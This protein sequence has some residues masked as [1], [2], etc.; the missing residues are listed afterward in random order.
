MRS[1]C[2]SNDLEKDNGRFLMMPWVKLSLHLAIVIP[3]SQFKPDNNNVIELYKY[4]K[5]IELAIFQ[6]FVYWFTNRRFDLLCLSVFLYSYLFCLFPFKEARTSTRLFANKTRWRY[7]K[8]GN[9]RPKFRQLSLL[10]KD[11]LTLFTTIATHFHLSFFLP[12]TLCI[13]TTTSS[14]HRTPTTT[15]IPSVF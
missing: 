2:S 5:M 7:A 12:Q 10:H 14:I 1:G 13:Y 11:P 8:S 15:F 3:H 4:N 6:T 9:L